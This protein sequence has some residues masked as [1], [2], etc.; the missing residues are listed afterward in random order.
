MTGEEI[1]RMLKEE[2]GLEFMP[3]INKEQEQQELDDYDEC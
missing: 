1:R 2:A 3:E